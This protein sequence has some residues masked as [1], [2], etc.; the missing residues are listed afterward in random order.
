MDETYNGDTWFEI[1]PGSEFGV[2]NLPFGVY[3]RTEAGPRKIGVAIGDSVLDVAAIAA[4]EGE[5][6]APLLDA[7]V[8]NPLLAAG[9]ATWRAVRERITTWLTDP[10]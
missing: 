3:S 5:D 7:E 8:L 10:A 6:F 2:A 9:R 1:P 4:V